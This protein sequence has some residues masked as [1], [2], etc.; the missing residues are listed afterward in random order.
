MALAAALAAC[1]SSQPAANVSAP[2]GPDA[3]YAPARVAP[4]VLEYA[5]DRS[6]F[7]PVLTER[8]AYPTQAEASAAYL[9]LMATGPTNDSAPASIR[10]FGCQPGALDAETARV[11][12]YPGPA[13]LCAVDYLDGDGRRLWREPANFVYAQGVWT[14]QPVYPPQSAVAWRNRESSPKDFWWWVPGRPRYQ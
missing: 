8:A 14:L 10:L 4:G 5:P 9:R 12:R 3:L 13:A 6:T 7:A 11:T 1:S 2:A